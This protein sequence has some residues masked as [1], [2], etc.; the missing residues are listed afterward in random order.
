[1]TK[2]KEKIEELKQKGEV[3]MQ[4]AAIVVFDNL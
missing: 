3:C 4:R 1:V 2:D